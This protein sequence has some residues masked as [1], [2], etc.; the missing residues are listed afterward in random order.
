M[1]KCC[2]FR[3]STFL[4]F[5][6]F[7]L[8]FQL[9]TTRE[10]FPCFAL[11]PPKPSLTGWA[12]AR[13]PESLPSPCSPGCCAPPVSW[14]RWR[15]PQVVCC[16][17]GAPI[18][19]QPLAAAGLCSAPALN[20]SNAPSCNCPWWYPPLLPS[21][22]PPP[23]RSIWSAPPRSRSSWSAWQ[24]LVVTLGTRPALV[25]VASPIVES[26]LSSNHCVTTIKQPA[27]PGQFSL[28]NTFWNLDRHNSQIDK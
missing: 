3:V 7:T 27:L 4:N 21:S 28:A 17:E 12:S 26:R 10:S 5:S 11:A 19:L 18:H 14:T 20:C 2:L 25:P 9:F 22:P 1:G 8:K 23:Q 15:G 6:A 13:W 24:G 16:L